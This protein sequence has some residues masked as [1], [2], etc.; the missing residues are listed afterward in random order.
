[1][2][3]AFCEWFLESSCFFYFAFITSFS[4][5]VHDFAALKKKVRDFSHQ[6]A[7]DS[8]CSFSCKVDSKGHTANKTK[9]T[10]A[11]QWPPADSRL[12]TWCVR[13]PS[14]VTQEPHV[15]NDSV[16]WLG[17][18]NTGF[19]WLPS[20]KRHTQI[21]GQWKLCW[22]IRKTHETGPC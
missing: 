5:L 9:A 12:S 18:E 21:F 8:P 13:A 15:R 16:F 1:M 10:D 3:S 2:R 20:A 19:T 7:D 22:H 14:G 11:H 17:C 6:R 4:L